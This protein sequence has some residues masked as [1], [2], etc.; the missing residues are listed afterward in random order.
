MEQETKHFLKADLLPFIKA[1]P[2]RISSNQ[3]VTFYEADAHYLLWRLL[4]NKFLKE[5]FYR[6]WVP[7][8]EP[9]IP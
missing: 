3:Q 9:A 1:S 8:K 6:P 2:S 7:L 4:G 5:S